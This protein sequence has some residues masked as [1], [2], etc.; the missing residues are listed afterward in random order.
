MKVRR[1]FIALATA[2]A[3]MYA[4]SLL[5]GRLFF[6]PLHPSGIDKALVLEAR[7]PRALAAVLT[8]ASL[9]AA[10]VCFQMVFRNYL[11]GPNILG[12]TSGSAFGAAIA[13]LLLPPSPSIVQ[14][15]SFA[16][17]L[18]AVL[19]ACWLS[20]LVGGDTLALILSGIVVSALFSAGIGVVKYVADPYNKLPAI[21]YWLLGSLAGVRWSDLLYPTPPM[22]AG[23]VGVLLLRWVLNIVSL[24]DEEALSLGLRVG[25]YKTLCILLATLATSAATSIMGMV[26]WVGVV[27]PHI[28]RL[29]VGHD[30]RR[31]APASILV[32]SMLMLA[33]DDIARSAYVCELPLSV[34]TSLVGAPVLFAILARRRILHAE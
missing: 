31:L 23:V 11:A 8:G 17:G 28:A 4:V 20:R 10:G 24:G 12:V 13:I 29:A 14:I 15:V 25:F 6:N 7:A 34:V 9:G 32:G 1:E 5:T 3:A 19:T 26:A 27:S 30:C 33:C 18:T 21:V 22:L 2:L 16:F